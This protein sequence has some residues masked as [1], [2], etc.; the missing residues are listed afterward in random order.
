V[1]FDHEPERATAPVSGA[2]PGALA[3]RVV[4][5]PRPFDLQAAF[6]RVAAALTLPADAIV[7]RDALDEIRVVTAWLASPIGRA[8]AVDVGRL[9]HAAAWRR[10]QAL[11]AP[12]PLFVEAS[13][14]AARP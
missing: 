3:G 14:A 12:G 9:G 13:G 2:V 5:A 6:A 4:P 10:V 1:S 7:P 8:A 11:A